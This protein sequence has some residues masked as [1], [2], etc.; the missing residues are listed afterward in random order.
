M[1]EVNP[2]SCRLMDMASTNGTKVNGKLVTTTDLKHGDP[3][4]AGRTAFA[5][6]I[7]QI[8]ELVSNGGPSRLPADHP[9]HDDPG[10]RH[11]SIRV[12]P[13]RS[14]PTSDAFRRDP[15]LSASSATGAGR[16]G[17]RLPRPATSRAAS[18]SPSRRSSPPSSAR[19]ESA[20]FLREASILR[21]LDHP[22][23]IRFRSIGH[24]DNRL[25]FAMDYAPGTDAAHPQAA[26]PAPFRSPR[27][28]RSPARPSKALAYAHARG[29]VHRDIK[30]HNILSAHQVEGESGEGRRLRP[31]R[32]S[33]RPR[34]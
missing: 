33:I 6:A 30:P 34:P 22:N 5:V 20:R 27:A 8:P 25:Y 2:P 32:G 7:E 4:L 21:Q 3:I 29:F 13:D 10:H 1:V 24:A 17:S 9:D 19:R 23:I 18:P 14:Y 28:V 16:H 15:R 26:S 11:G 31:G 12:R